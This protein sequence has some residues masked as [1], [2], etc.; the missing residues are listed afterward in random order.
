MTV[1][2]FFLEA[3]GSYLIKR[4]A[5]PALDYTLT[6]VDE[7]LRKLAEQ[8]SPPDWHGQPLTPEQK[9]FVEMLPALQGN[10]SR[11]ARLRSWLSPQPRRGIIFLSLIHI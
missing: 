8:S 2:S 7:E 6:L 10:T 9:R 3:L 4:A 11:W 5:Q 1:S